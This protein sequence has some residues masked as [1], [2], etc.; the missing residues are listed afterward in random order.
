MIPAPPSEG[1]DGF[2][3]VND[4]RAPFALADGGGGEGAFTFED[5][6]VVALRGIK[7]H[8]DFS[9]VNPPRSWGVQPTISNPISATICGST[10]VSLPFSVPLSPLFQRPPG[11]R[12]V[13]ICPLYSWFSIY[14]H[15]AFINSGAVVFWLFCR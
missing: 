4:F 11:G 12:T 13:F 1:P 10:E 9:L 8:L 5:V 3:S 15:L 14:A 6:A 2:S 7:Y